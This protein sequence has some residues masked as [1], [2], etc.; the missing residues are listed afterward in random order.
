MH[1]VSCIVSHDGDACGLV[2]CG[3]VDCGLVDC[4]LPGELAY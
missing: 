1:R 4:G 3:L 2:D